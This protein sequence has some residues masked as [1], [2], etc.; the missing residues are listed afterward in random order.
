MG[1]G[2]QA[3][4]IDNL[5]NSSVEALHW[6]PNSADS[7]HAS[8]VFIRHDNPQGAIADWSSY[9]WQQKP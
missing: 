1:V 9:R 3:V 5:H 4:V 6:W 2:S 7:A 8:T